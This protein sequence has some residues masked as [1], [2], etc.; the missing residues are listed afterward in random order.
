ME[1]LDN[2]QIEQNSPEKEGKRDWFLAFI[3]FIWLAG[4]VLIFTLYMSGDLGSSFTIPRI[5]SF[6]YDAF[7]IIPASV[8]QFIIAT[9]FIIFGLRKKK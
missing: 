9:L 4:A 8:L 3:G 2:Q 7:G 1:P 6:F 5:M